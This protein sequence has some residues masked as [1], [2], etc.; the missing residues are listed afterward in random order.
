M[1]VRAQRHHWL[2]TIV[3]LLDSAFFLTDE[4]QFAVSDIV[5]RLLIALNIPD[6]GQPYVLPIP[7]AHEVSGSLYALGLATP[8]ESGLVRA[9]RPA[10]AAD[11]VVS[12]EAWRQALVSLL[13]SAY[14][15]LSA[16]ETFMVTKVFT[17]LLAAIGVPLRA[18]AFFPN[19]VVRAYHE[20]DR[21]VSAT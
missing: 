11:N 7:V 15:D 13:T 1:T 2:N 17:D 3:G 9:V 6:R 4:E 21:G 8:R 19:T 10:S 20:V 16:D 12:L 5:R 14:P 18:A